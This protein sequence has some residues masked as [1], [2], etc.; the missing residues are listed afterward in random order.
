MNDSPEDTGRSNLTLQIF[1]SQ[2]SECVAM[3]MRLS[4]DHLQ[5]LPSPEPWAP[6]GLCVFSGLPGMRFDSDGEAEPSHM[7]GPCL[8]TFFFL[9][10]PSS[11]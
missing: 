2:E 6:W 8:V 7:P 4:M 10:R 3:E 9:T 5:V 11:L 1:V